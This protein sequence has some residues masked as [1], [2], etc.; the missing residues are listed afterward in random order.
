M[1]GHRRQRIPAVVQ[2]AV[3]NVSASVPADVFTKDLRYNVGAQPISGH[4]MRR[5][6]AAVLAAVPATKTM[7]SQKIYGECLSANY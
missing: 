2:A 5:V 4:A 1:S 6:L 7:R 3:P